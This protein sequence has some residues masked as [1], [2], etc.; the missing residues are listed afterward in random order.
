MAKNTI[1]EKLRVMLSGITKISD[2]TDEEIELKAKEAGINLDE[3]EASEGEGGHLVTEDGGAKH[4]PTMK[5]GKPD[6]GLMGAAHAALHGGYRGNKYEGPGKEG[7]ISKLKSMY[8]SEGMDWPG[9]KDKEKASDSGFS[10]MLNSIDL[11]SAGTDSFGRKAY[12]IPVAL[13]G[14]WV[15]GQPFSIT[16]NHLNAIKKNFEKRGNGEIVVDFEHASEQPF[17][18]AK[19]GPVP[20]AGWMSDFRVEPS[21]GSHIL[22]VMYAP[23]SEA[24]QLISAQKY[25]YLSPAIDWGFPDKKTGEPQGATLTSVALTNHPFLDELPAIQMRQT[26]W[27]ENSVLLTDLQGGKVMTKKEQIEQMRV[28]LGELRTA[29]KTDEAKTLLAD[30]QKLEM[31]EYEMSDGAPKMKVMKKGGKYGLFSGDGKCMGYVTA[32]EMRACM[33]EGGDEKEPDD[34]TADKKAMREAIKEFKASG[35]GEMKLSDVKDLVERGK[36]SI[37]ADKE[38]QRVLMSEAVINGC[39]DRARASFVAN[40]HRNITIQDFVAVERA[41]AILNKAVGDGKLVPAHRTQLFEDVVA[42][43]EKWEKLFSSAVPLFNIGRSTGAPGSTDGTMPTVQEEVD[44]T[45]K[46][47][48]SDHK[49]DKDLT[50]AQAMRMT[51]QEDTQKGGSLAKRYEASRAQNKA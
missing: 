39:L 14:D 47:F 34:D 30:I 6:H 17:E 16:L 38:G 20:A 27:C 41:D 36:K 23:T 49:D 32:D 18:A 21:N 28:K 37:A 45:V 44:T 43:P 25:R 42:N 13:T 22:T 50:Y 48:M 12:R 26:Y 46:K 11:T 1:I 35:L 33:A 29:N 31:Q 15:K 10:T 3:L 19:G 4:L 7:A 24:Q 5:N 40:Q 2:S 8:K 51:F 9:E